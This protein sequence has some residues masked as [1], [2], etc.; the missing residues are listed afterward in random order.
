MKI[1]WYFDSISK[2]REVKNWIKTEIF[3]TNIYDLSNQIFCHQVGRD[4]GEKFQFVFDKYFSEDLAISSDC[5][6]I[7][8]KIILEAF[9]SIGG[10][11]ELVFEPCS[12]G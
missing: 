12:D 10:R 2:T 7:S 8:D 1:C 9:E 3:A 11:N 6:T 5:I 4:L